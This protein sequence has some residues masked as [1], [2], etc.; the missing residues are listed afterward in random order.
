VLRFCKKGRYFYADL[1]QAST[2]VASAAL[3]VERQPR[4]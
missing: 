1:P 4:T 2:R 3:R